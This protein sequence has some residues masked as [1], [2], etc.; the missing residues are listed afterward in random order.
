VLKLQN[1]KISQGFFIFIIVWMNV[2]TPLSLDE[3]TPSLPAILQ[4]L[5]SSTVLMQLTVTCYMIGIFIS[6]LFMGVLSDRY[7]RRRTI[8]CGIPIFMLGSILCVISH[9]STMLLAGRVLQG[10]GIGGVGVMA[11]AVIADAFEGEDVQRVGGIMGTAYGFI[12]LAAPLIGGLIQDFLGWRANFGFLLLIAI[13]SY[14]LDLFFLP[15]THQTSERH[16]IS[17]SNLIKSF[18]H[19]LTHRYYMLS[20]MCLALSWSS[21]V[22]FAVMGPFL[23]EEK[24]GYSASQYGLFALLIGLGF[25]VGST[26]FTFGLKRI[27]ITGLKYVGIILMLSM[28]LILLIL[29]AI[30][31]FNIVSVML[32]VFCFM[33][34]AGICFPLFYS[35]AMAAVPEYLGIANSLIGAQCMVWGC[36]V[37]A[38]ITQLHA[39]S[40]F[41]MASVYLGVSIVLALVSA[42]P[43]CRK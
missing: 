16:T 11:G 24:L 12:A 39:H 25:L 30:G 15:E 14:L 22:I 35:A 2:L 40:I 10:L 18:K 32:P 31:Y 33:I 21:C 43:T 37:T 28:G 38:I 27:G 42:I 7:G 36:F 26:C 23:V 13:F 6:Q 34:G 29:P 20:A 1:L 5:N 8:L 19:V 9:T 3:Y 41:A 4:S 17:L